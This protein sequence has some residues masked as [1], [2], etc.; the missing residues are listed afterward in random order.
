M[1]KKI[2]QQLEAI[3][4]KY[5]FTELAQA[6]YT[7]PRLFMDTEYMLREW[8]LYDLQQTNFKGRMN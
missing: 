8:Q 6:I 5:G 4:L 1:K 3:L 7:T 2:R